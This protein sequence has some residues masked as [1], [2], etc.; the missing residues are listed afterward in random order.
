MDILLFNQTSLTGGRYRFSVSFVEY[1]L[2]NGLESP[3]KLLNGF[4]RQMGC[5][6]GDTGGRFTEYEDEPQIGIQMLGFDWG[7]LELGTFVL[8]L[9]IPPFEIK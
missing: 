2:S 1:L 8:Q 5:P 4:I 9:P 7:R 3:H 6:P